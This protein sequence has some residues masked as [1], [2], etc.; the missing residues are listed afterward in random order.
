M[1]LN[2]ALHNKIED[3]SEDGNALLENGD[4]QATVAKWNQALDLVPEPKSDWEAATWLYG[5]IGDAYFEGR[6]LDSAKAT[7]FDAL[8]CPGGTENP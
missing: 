4:R 6:D 7:F 1:E 2:A 3:L 5:S 8:N